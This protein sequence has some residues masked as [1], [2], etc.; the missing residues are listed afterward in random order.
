MQL[1]KDCSYGLR[2]IISLARRDGDVD[3]AEIAEEHNVALG[4]LAKVIGALVHQGLVEPTGRNRIRLAGDPE[5]VTIADIV[6]A[7]GETLPLQR[8]L[9]HDDVIHPCEKMEACG[10]CALWGMLQREITG[11]LAHH[12]LAEFVKAS[13]KCDL[14]NDPAEPTEG[15]EN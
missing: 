1:S 4:Y 10:L 14:K 8:C 2:V 3:L 6:A 5:M 11:V 7:Y 13:G 15:A 12:S 9:M